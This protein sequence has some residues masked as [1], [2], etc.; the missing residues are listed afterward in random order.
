MRAFRFWR[1]SSRNVTYRFRP[2]SYGNMAA[3]AVPSMMRAGIWCGAAV[4]TT[5]PF[6]LTESFCSGQTDEIALDGDKVQ[7]SY[8]GR[9]ANG[10]V[11]DTAKQKAPL[12]FVI[13]S[14]NMLPGFDRAVHGMKVPAFIFFDIQTSSVHY[15]ALTFM[16]GWRN[17]RVHSSP[18]RC[19]WFFP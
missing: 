12:S 4:L 2:R 3:S 6:F 16:S 13:G 5:T 15:A 17:Q 18:C 10:T 19:I 11:F 7:I 9:L 8:E 14:G 1:R